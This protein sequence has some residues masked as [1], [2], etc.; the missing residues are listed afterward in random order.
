MP[1]DLPFNIGDEV[2]HTLKKKHRTVGV[3]KD[4]FQDLTKSQ[5]LVLWRNR[6]RGQTWETEETIQRA[7]KS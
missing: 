7:S 6:G 4:I 3:I 2:V 1:S 5:Y